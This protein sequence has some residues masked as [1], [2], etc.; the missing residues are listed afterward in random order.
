MNEHGRLPLNRDHKW[1]VRLNSTSVMFST[2]FQ[3]HLLVSEALT[4]PHTHTE[5]L[6]QG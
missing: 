2:N 3:G 4:P 1:E 5:R 6:I